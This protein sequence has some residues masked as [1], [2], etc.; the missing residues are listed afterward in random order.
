MAITAVAFSPNGLRDHLI[1]ASVDST[2]HLWSTTLQGRELQQLQTYSIDVREISLSEDESK[3]F[4]VSKLGAVKTL[5]VCT[6]HAF[7]QLSMSDWVWA[8]FSLDGN[9]IICMTSNGHSHLIDC[10]TGHITEQGVSGTTKD[11]HRQITELVFSP[12]KKILFSF[13]KW[14]QLTSPKGPL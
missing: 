7:D 11:R 6:G 4:C 10:W 13:W 8:D 14:R 2:I 5:Y 12:T 9:E 1:L 3:I